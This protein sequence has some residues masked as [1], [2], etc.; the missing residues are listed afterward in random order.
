[1]KESV[2]GVFQPTY[3]SRA[4]QNMLAPG[5]GNN[6]TPHQNDIL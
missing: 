5:A 3:S 4:C 1:M 2:L 6:L